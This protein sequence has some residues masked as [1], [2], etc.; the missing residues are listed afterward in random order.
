[1]RDIKDILEQYM[2]ANGVTRSEVMG[3]IG[4]QPQ[5]WSKLAHDAK[6]SVACEIFSALGFNLEQLIH[7]ILYG[8]PNTDT[9]AKCPHCGKV[10]EITIRLNNYG[11]R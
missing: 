10:W 1:M 11:K 5:A 8:K 9:F 3:K 2:D 7:D 6:W 4:R